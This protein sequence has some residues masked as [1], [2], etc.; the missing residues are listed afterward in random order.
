MAHQKQLL[1]QYFFLGAGIYILWTPFGAYLAK[2]S[3]TYKLLIVIGCMV[4]GIGNII[5][6]PNHKLTALPDLLVFVFVEDVLVNLGF[7]FIFI[8]VMPDFMDT[9]RRDYSGMPEGLMADISAAFFNCAL[10]LGLLAGPIAGGYLTQYFKFQVASSGM[11]LLL[12]GFSLCYCL[13]GGACTVKKYQSVEKSFIHCGRSI[14]S[15]YNE[16]ISFKEINS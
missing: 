10:S 9:F 12:I 13:F 8:P 3:Q 4:T 1:D 15:V 5:I 7:I 2:Y 14:V 6:G 16:K 11:G